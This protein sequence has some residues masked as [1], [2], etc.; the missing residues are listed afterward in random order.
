VAELTGLPPRALPGSTRE[1]LELLHPEDRA[2]FRERSIDAGRTGRRTDVEYRLRRS[3]GRWIHI[4]Q[5]IEPMGPSV[6]GRWFSTL[7]DVT[8]FAEAQA[9][10]RRAEGNYRSVFDNATVGL[11]V[12]DSSG[13]VASANPAL[14]RM[15]GYATTE[16]MMRDI[17]H[18]GRQVYV[19]AE[20]RARYR[21]RLAESGQV[22]DFETRWRRRD[23]REIWV[24]LHGNE[25]RDAG[26]RLVH[27]LG[28]A[29][30]I[31]ERKKAQDKLAYLAYYDE[32]TGLANRRLLVERI[33]SAISS[34]AAG[35]FA[36]VLVNVE[37]FK[38]LNDSLGREA[39][40]AVLVELAARLVRLAGD[41]TRVARLAA[42]QFAV[43]VPGV[44]GEERI[45]RIVRAGTS[46]V[47]G[48]PLS[49]RETQ[50][51]IAVNSGIALFPTD[52]ANPDTLLRNA[53]AALKK[54]RGSGVKYLFYTQKMTERAA[55]RL[56]LESRLR[57]A[58]EREEFVLHYQPK[59][60]EGGRIA[61]V[62]AL[63]RWLSPEE[64]LVPPDRF[65]SV[66]EETGLIVPAGR[67][68]LGQAVR[69]RHAWL[70]K[71][72]AAPRVAVNVSAAQLRQADFVQE[73]G[74]ALRGLGAQAGIDLEITES[75]VMEDIEA[76]I[77]KLLA[78]RE[79]GVEIAVDDFGTGYSSLAYLA[80]LPVQALKIDRAFVHAMQK[81]AD[82]MTLVGT[83]VSLAHS[84]RLKVVAEGVETAAEAE[85]LRGLRCDEMQGYFFSRP[86]PAAEL[87]GLLA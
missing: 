33:A 20:A 59:V 66:L 65:I 16:E 38:T 71:G 51:R 9:A 80:K 35:A 24:A 26:G 25:V 4:R 79:L 27:Q 50:L 47:E 52:G 44:S 23:G 58:V 10:A 54:V 5:M 55:E 60:G 29:E 37:R 78:A 67:W 31:T 2:R 13:R 77:P 19:D 22:S 30:D 8:D 83:I 11:F 32:L 56:Q 45:A 81:D 64:G 12:V 1:W 7:Q 3:D 75:L 53:E 62:E 74:E 84:L 42:D 34:N 48:E 61:G 41:A 72:L 40:D 39:G 63:I 36:L 57:R 46:Q 6:D 43:L 85:V 82:A 76:T 15:L 49:W 28:I 18:V 68:A 73:L 69:D 14:A 86:V 21:A 87:E 70:A 17:A